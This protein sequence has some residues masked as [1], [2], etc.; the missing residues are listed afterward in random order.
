MRPVTDLRRAEK[1]FEVIS[2]YQPSGDQPTAIK[3]LTERL[4]AGEKD[5]VLLGATGTGK[6]ATTAW[7]VEQVQR[8]QRPAAGHAGQHPRLRRLRADARQRRVRGRLEG[9]GG[10]ARAGRA[11]HRGAGR[12]HRHLAAPLAPGTAARIFT[13]APVPEGADLVVMGAYSHSRLREA[14]L[15][16]ATRHM[17][18]R[19]PLPILMAR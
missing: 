17:L 18:E 11:R 8:L 5:I 13:G 15:G 16:G 6:S 19:A 7:L 14:I 2:P 1:P 9:R 4:N 10:R 3:E 12:G